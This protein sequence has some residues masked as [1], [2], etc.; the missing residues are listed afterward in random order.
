[1]S[2]AEQEAKYGPSWR[3]VAAVLARAEVLT[4][5]EVD[6][7]AAAWFAA[8]YKARDA[9]R[10]AAKHVWDPDGITWDATWDVA[11]DAAWDAAK[12]AAINGPVWDAPWRVS[13][14]YVAGDAAVAAAVFH[15]IG[16]HGFTQAH[17]DTLT[18]PWV[19]VCGPIV[20][21]VTS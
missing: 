10:D 14:R 5:G 4:P 7:V 20:A 17:Y 11:W 1:M 9:A 3:L 12:D 8:E 13:A 2:D 16:T 21:E 18:G 15:L 19:S 6:A